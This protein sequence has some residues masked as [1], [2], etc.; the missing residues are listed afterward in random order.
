M[1]DDEIGVVD[2]LESKS[3][4]KDLKMLSGF[5]NFFEGIG[6]GWSLVV[7]RESPKEYKGFLEEIPI[8]N[9]DEVRREID[10]AYLARKWGGEV[11]KLLLRS[12]NGIFSKRILIEMR[13]Y[14][15]M[16]NGHALGVAEPAE[17]L[18]TLAIVRLL[19][20]LQPSPPP[21]PPSSDLMPL[22]TV[23][24][25]KAINPPAQ[26]AQSTDSKLMDTLQA[27]SK[28]RDLVQP[29]PDGGA[30]WESLAAKV[31]E[32]LMPL[33]A[34]KVTSGNMPRPQAPR[35][36]VVHMPPPAMPAPSATQAQPPPPSV[37][38]T[39]PP[40]I[41]VSREDDVLDM[42]RSQLLQMEGEQV[43]DLFLAALDEL[44]QNKKAAALDRLEAMIY[45]DEPETTNPP[46]PIP[47]D[48]SIPG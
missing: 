25:E 42:A 1:T 24:L 15:P 13:T 3:D 27:I 28:M 8:D 11:L 18:D 37:D 31:I 26:M 4:E 34:E 40:I 38:S 12:P 2:D 22:L 14:P 29:A 39:E 36:P 47:R 45:E 44:P 41:N 5:D 32:S 19:K 10:L 21:P 35:S 7:V 30:V 17:R 33:V 23:L 16:K 46:T 43:T 20:E 48:K 9:P 6:S